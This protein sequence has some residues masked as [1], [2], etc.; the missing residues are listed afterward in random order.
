MVATAS[1]LIPALVEATLTDEQTS[2]VWD[3]ASGMDSISVRLPLENPFCTN[4]LYPPMKLIPSSCAALSRVCA[5]RMAPLRLI[6]PA[7]RAM[8][9]T[10][11]RLLMIGMPYSLEMSSPVLTRSM[12]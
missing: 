10:D 6:P 9:V 7:I 8:G 12:A 3:K 1:I 5:M 4:A 11:T 2:S